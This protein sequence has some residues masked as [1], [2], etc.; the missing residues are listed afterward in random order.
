MQNIS[1]KALGSRAGFPRE[2][3]TRL[4]DPSGVFDLQSA[5]RNVHEVSDM[6]DVLG[7]GAS[8]HVE[9]DFRVSMTAEM[10][11]CGQFVLHL[12]LVDPHRTDI[13]RIITTQRSVPNKSNQIKSGPD[14]I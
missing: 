1:T 8:L 9:H 10:F 12:L 3:G 4:S 5:A 14:L 2:S 13:V 6:L 7:P 11:T